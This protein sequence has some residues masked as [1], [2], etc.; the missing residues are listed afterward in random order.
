LVLPVLADPEGVVSLSNLPVG[1]IDV[2]AGL[3]ARTA[4]RGR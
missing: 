2:R 4:P 3:E 1:S